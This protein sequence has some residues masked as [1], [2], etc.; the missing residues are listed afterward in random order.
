MIVDQLIREEIN[1]G[2]PSERIILGGFSQGTS[3]LYKH[4]NRKIC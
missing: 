4:S 1:N 2:I 3:S